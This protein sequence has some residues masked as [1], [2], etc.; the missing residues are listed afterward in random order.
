M[1]RKL[2]VTAVAVFL[3]LVASGCGKTPTSTA[4][5]GAAPV[6]QPQ[7]QSQPS[8]TPLPT[9]TPLPSPTPTVTSSPTVIPTSTSTPVPLQ[10]FAGQWFNEDPDTKDI[11]HIEIDVEGASVMVHVWGKCEPKDCDWGETQADISEAEKGILLVKWEFSFKVETQKMILLSDGR[12]QVTKHTHF[13]DN[14][15]RSD[16][17]AIEYFVRK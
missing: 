10:A 4:S 11:T 2:F 6:Q 17:E 8:D 7:Q 12:L 14:S 15:G 5:T 3:F 1:I 16:R 9:N 13:T